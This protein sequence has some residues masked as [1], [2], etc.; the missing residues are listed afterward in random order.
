MRS[1]GL[2][3]SRQWKIVSDCSGGD[4]DIEMIHAEWHCKTP[5]SLLYAN[6]TSCIGNPIRI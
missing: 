3:F 2:R 1:K 4:E 5:K 6:P